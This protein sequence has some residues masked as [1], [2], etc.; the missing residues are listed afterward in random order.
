MF[1]FNDDLHLNSISS[2]KIWK[3]YDNSQTEEFLNAPLVR[4]IVSISC[5]LTKCRATVNIM[6]FW[7]KKLT[8]ENLGFWMVGEILAGDRKNER[9][10]FASMTK[11]NHIKTLKMTKINCYVIQT[12]RM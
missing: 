2:V 6:Y 1:Q 8:E 4:Q 10:R 11:T 12:K 9:F 3:L 7:K 5:L